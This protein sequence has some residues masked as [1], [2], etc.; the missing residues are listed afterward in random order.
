MVEAEVSTLDS[1]SRDGSDARG[2]LRQHLRRLIWMMEQE[3][4]D[5]LMQR[6]LEWMSS[7]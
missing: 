7:R 4:G 3:V 1:P 2:G 6:C 5:E